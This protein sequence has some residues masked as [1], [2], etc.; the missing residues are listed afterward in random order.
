MIEKQLTADTLASVLILDSDHTLEP[1]P[2][3][4]RFQPELT[5]IVPFIAYQE[6][7]HTLPG[8]CRLLAMLPS[9]INDQNVLRAYYTDVAFAVCKELYFAER[10]GKQCTVIHHAFPSTYPQR[11]RP[12]GVDAV[13]TLRQLVDRH[14]F[15]LPRQISERNVQ[16]WEYACKLME[17]AMQVPYVYWS[18]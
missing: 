8:S 2:E 14:G 10:R 15:P 13:A 16:H 4:F 1:E 11:I 5:L 7:V 12:P 17:S 6:F 9:S 18:Y 3:P